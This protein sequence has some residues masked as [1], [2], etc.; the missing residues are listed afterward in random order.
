MGM[1]QPVSEVPAGRDTFTAIS[2]FLPVVRISS[3]RKV[4][5]NTVRQFFLL[6]AHRVGNWP[7]VC[8]GFTRLELHALRRF[9]KTD[10]LLQVVDLDHSRFN[11]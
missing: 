10:C 1:P 5:G 6:V 8:S 4:I 7:V 2:E 3:Q 11:G 9:E